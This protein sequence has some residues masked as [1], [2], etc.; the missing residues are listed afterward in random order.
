MKRV[1]T[2]QTY[3][4]VP[5][6][7]Y[8]YYNIVDSIQRLISRAGFLQQCEQWRKNQSDTV[9]GFIMDVSDGRL[10]REWMV[11]DDVP[12]LQVPGNLLL[13]LNVDW[14]QPFE[15]TQYSVGVI[16]LV[17]QNLP[18]ALRF[19]PENIIIV[20]TIPGPSEPNCNHL[21]PYLE[22]M[23][24]D[25]IK[26]WQGVHVKTPHSVFST[27]V[28]RVALSYICCDL[29]ATRKVCGFYGYNANYG[30]SK[31]LKAFPST[32]S[33]AP[34]YSGFRR[35]EWPLRTTSSHRLV[36]NRA[37]VAATRTSREK[38]EHE[39]GVRFSELLR[40]PYL[41]I[42]RCHLVDPMHNLFLGTAKHM[43][44]IWK[45]KGY[46][47]PALLDII[48]EK[49]DSINPPYNI[50]RIPGKIAAGFASFTAEQLMWWTI[51]YSPVV[52]RGVLPNQDY[53]LWC[54][55]S[56]AC[57]HLCR[58]YIS[59]TKVNQADELLLS[60]C[61]G[62]ERLYGRDF[63]TPNLHMHCHLKD[64]L[65]D[66]GPICSFWLFSFERYNGIL[67]SMKMSWHAPE[68][69]LLHKFSSIQSLASVTLPVDVPSELVDCF[70]AAKDHRTAL[71][72]AVFN[73][74]AIL[75]Y[76][77]NMM[78]QLQDVC[79]LKLPFQHLIPPGRE[80][81]M[82]E[83][84]KENLMQMYIGLYGSGNIIHVPLRYTQY[85][86]IKVFEQTFTSNRS[87]TSRSSSVLAIWP[88]SS[89]SLITAQPSIEHIRV[90][91]IDH[92]ILHTPVLTNAQ[93]GSTSEPHLLA[94][95]T[96]YQDHPHKTELGNGII[97]SASV[98]EPSY[99]ASFMPVSRIISRCAICITTM[100]FDYGEDKV[101][102]VIPIRRHSLL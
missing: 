55:F 40:L 51:L 69:Q 98:S 79:A 32:F 87:R 16:Y 18:R 30:C 86:L 75:K 12:F 49:V 83:S 62:F 70:Q 3:K 93:G 1:K 39:A 97:L 99:A 34:D 96:W 71:P 48:Q 38:I 25:L 78:C 76:E 17:V 2:G 36:A 64:C 4:V 59:E 6:K 27:M 101:C 60:F 72:D 20:S 80:K 100:Q 35:E 22:P 8:V 11:K 29:P 67:E 90:G 26:L 82:M 91:T 50:G 21:N 19:K 46:L 14:F 89:G 56:K 65:L 15:H 73:G 13:M 9:S 53:S 43:F 7:V 66:V 45:R 74:C 85:S 54:L 33:T 94:R 44:T 24:D 42:V 92:F 61:H 47:T 63:C 84:E 5:R 57:S 81:F 58:P 95:I 68:L 102:V 37:K 41:D 23:V 77:Q 31:C 10:W 28:L 88:H 52:L